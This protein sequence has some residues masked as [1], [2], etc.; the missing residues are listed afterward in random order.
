MDANQIASLFENNRTPFLRADYSDD[1]AWQRII[2]ALGRSEAVQVELELGTF[3]HFFV[4]VESRDL[5]G[6]SVESLTDGWDREREVAGFVLI[7]DRET[8]RQANLGEQTT[9]LY[10]DLTVSEADVQEFGDV[11]GRAFRCVVTEIASI[12]VNLDL[13]NMDFSEYADHAD[14]HGGVFSGFAD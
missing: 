12:N 6:L 13:G 14:E 9:V 4:P 8:I 11:Y 5:D 7:A 3:E 2:D 1:A 10:V